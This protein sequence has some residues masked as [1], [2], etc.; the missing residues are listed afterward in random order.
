VS[1]LRYFCLFAYSGVR[2]ILCFVA[3]RLVFC[4]PSVVSFSRLFILDCSF[5][6][7]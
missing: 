4:V 7:L 5:S 1:Y 2:Y 6:V 3:L